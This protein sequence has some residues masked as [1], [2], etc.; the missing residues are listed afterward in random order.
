MIS[1]IIPTIGRK[2]L[3]RTLQ[4][5]EKRPED[6]I[7]VEVDRPPSGRWGNDQRNIA[8]KKAKGKYLAFIDDDDFYIEGHREFMD[9]AIKDN[10]GKPILFKILYP[11]GRIIWDK[12]EIVPGN[13]STQMILVPNIPKMLYYWKDGR[14]M[15]DFIFVDNWGWYD[16]DVVWREEIIILMGHD[17]EI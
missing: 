14:N 1:F 7:L 4:S 16:K 5:I 12:K 17:Y 2:T 6:E 8:M 9:Q 13:I 11:N 3:G 15:A 10:P